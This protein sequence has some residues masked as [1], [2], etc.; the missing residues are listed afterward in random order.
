MKE[1]F[2]ALSGFKKAMV[3]YGSIL[4]L[5][6]LVLWFAVWQY[7]AAYEQA[8]PAGAIN[9]YV[10]GTLKRELEAQLSEYCADNANKYQSEEDLTA[11]LTA[12]VLEQD[13]TY[14]KNTK[15][16]TSEA[17]VYTLYC[18]DTAMCDVKLTAG[19]AGLLSFGQTPW[20][21]QPAD[22]EL[23]RLAK[24]VTIYAPAEC[25]VKLNGVKLGTTVM[26]EPVGYYPEF[27]EYETTIKKS[28]QLQGYAVEGILVDNIIVEFDEGHELKMAENG[29]Y[30]I[31]PVC[32]EETEATLLEYG[33]Q[34]VEAY[35]AYTSNSGTYYSVSRYVA[36]GSELLSRLYKS[37]DGMSWVH[38]TTGKLTEVEVSNLEYYGNVATFDSSYSLK[39]KSGD[40]D[41]N[42]HVVMVQAAYG[43]RV[44]DIEMY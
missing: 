7:A 29:D 41:G 6:L 43:W 21:V 9:A 10:E 24:T 36:P 23:D 1:K 18:G 44:T 42:M 16:Y 40:W 20:N 38:Y 25:S 19:E 4:L 28:A 8:Q 13:W 5:I 30:Y 37:L 31:A 27:A 33:Q 26:T 35:T 11:V 3:I 14:R 2:N 12:K 17:P 32:D 34:F 15:Q 39:L 22:V